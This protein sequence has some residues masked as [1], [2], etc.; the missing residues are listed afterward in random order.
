MKEK[1]AVGDTVK[2]V[3]IPSFILYRDIALSL[4]ALYKVSQVSPQGFSIHLLGISR[5]IH[6]KYIEFVE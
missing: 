6:S 1:F 4:T 3:E 2:F 5:S